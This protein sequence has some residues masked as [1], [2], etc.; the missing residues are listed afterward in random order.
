[1]KE[2]K[3]NKKTTNTLN[4]NPEKKQNAHQ[5]KEVILFHLFPL[6]NAEWMF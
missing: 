6:Y 5:G 4:K 3:E 2:K 1:M